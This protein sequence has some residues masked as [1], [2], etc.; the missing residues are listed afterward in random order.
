MASGWALSFPGFPRALSCCL[1]I[2]SI[3]MN[4]MHLTF[5]IAYSSLTPPRSC[6]GGHTY[7]FFSAAI[8]GVQRCIL[9]WKWHTSGAPLYL[10]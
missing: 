1:G 10:N 4:V 5:S 3:L 9:S 2:N 6:R 7:V 8:D